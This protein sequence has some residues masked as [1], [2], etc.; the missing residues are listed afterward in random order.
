M[1]RSFSSLSPQEALHVAIFIEERNAGIYQ[2]F[3]EMFAEFR[4]PD[5]LEIAAVFWDMSV[6]EKRHSSQLQ[7]KYQERY[8][9]ASCTITEDDLHEMIEVPR[10]ESSDVF[11][12]SKSSHATPRER[13]LKVALEAEHSAQAFYAELVDRTD[14]TA[15]RSLYR[16]LATM[17]DGHVN[18]LQG[19]LAMSVHGDGN[20]V[21]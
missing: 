13:A 19:M 11:E 8:G 9:N 10:L 7:T 16:E 18:Y 3:A 6:E 2:R 21:Q 12:V 1:T 20:E 17:E 14:D 5:S 4:D 15:L